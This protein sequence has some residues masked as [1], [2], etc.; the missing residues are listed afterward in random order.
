[1]QEAWMGRLGT[2]LKESQM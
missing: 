2:D 1:M